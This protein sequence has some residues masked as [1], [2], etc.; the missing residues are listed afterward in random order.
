M[1]AHGTYVEATDTTACGE[2][3]D[4]DIGAPGDQLGDCVRVR[5][6]CENG[7]AA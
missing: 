2:Y 3:G 5:R 7:E 1:F 6:P 4:C